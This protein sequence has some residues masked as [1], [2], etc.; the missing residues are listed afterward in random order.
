MSL[1]I[2]ID[3]SDAD[4]AHFQEAVKRAQSNVTA[5]SPTEITNAARQLLIDGEGKQVPEFI[6]SRLG[7]LGSLIA[8]VLDEGWALSGEDKERVLTALSYFADPKDVIPDSVPV[9][10]LLDDAIMIE[11]CVRELKHEL[12]SY[13][14]FCSFR[15][16]EACGARARSRDR[17]PRRVAGRTPHRAA[18]THAPAPFELQQFRRRRRQPVPRRLIR[19]YRGSDHEGACGRP[20]CFCNRAVPIA[21][22]ARSY[23]ACPVGARS[24]R[25][26]RR[27]IPEP[28]GIA[29]PALRPLE[30]RDHAHAA[31]GADRDQGAAGA[32]FGQELGCGG[33]D[34]RAGG[35]EGVA[36]GEAGT[37]HVE[38][39]RIDA[40]HRLLAAEAVATIG[41]ALPGAQGA[42][43]LRGEGFVDLVEIEVLQGQ[44]VRRAASRDTATVGAISRP[45]PPTKSTAATL[46]C[47]R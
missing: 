30:D 42:Q 47:D 2:T 35:G 27:R 13:E 38:L 31:G 6:A 46:A 10:G 43:H 22:R 36:E 37:H 14:D 20:R 23:E 8:M 25:D 39:G 16:G 32:A 18:G 15:T 11:L 24:A 7:K 12:E 33:D 44:A 5:K 17:R 21:R 9:V 40:A 1:S 28:P 34:A 29:I 26:R 41:R 45:S 3:L 19:P 4:L